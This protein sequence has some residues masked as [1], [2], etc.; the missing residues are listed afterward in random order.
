[1]TMTLKKSWAQNA[2]TALALAATLATPVLQAEAGEKTGNGGVGVVCRNTRGQITKATLLDI[3]EGENLYGQTYADNGLDL[4]TR[5]EVIETRM[6]RNV[7]FLEDFKNQVSQ[8]KSILVFL[9]SGIGLEPTNDAFPII[10]Q[11][12]CRFE[13]V[14]NYDDAENRL[15]IDQEI[16][17][18]LDSVNRAALYVHEAVY[19]MARK[20]V[21][22][23][24]S[25]RSRKL[26]A[27]LVARTQFGDVIE[28]LMA[29]VA[30]RQ[31]PPPPPPLPVRPLAFRNI[32]EGHY[33]TD[34]SGLCPFRISKNDMTGEMWL[35]WEGQNCSVAGNVITLRCSG[36]SCRGDRGQRNNEYWTGTCGGKS[37][38]GWLFSYEVI[39]MGPGEVE[40]RTIESSSKF[41]ECWIDRFTYYQ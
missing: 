41:E 19:A 40:Y 38:V 10:N 1:M 2:L 21:G 33:R 35:T 34:A 6:I 3:F 31:D 24:S 29:Q 17:N 32:Q 14:A 25:V 9:P 27:Y 39:P 30:K 26:T 12:G 36:W 20:N 13:Q 5:L 18:A 23:S 28:T 22:D 37:T 15:Y 7:P 16:F 8:V 4:E 11:R